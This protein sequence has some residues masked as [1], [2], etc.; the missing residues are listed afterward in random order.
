MTEKRLILGKKGEDFAADFLIKKGYK[1]KERNYRSPLG[2]IDI[3]ATSGKTIVFIEVKTRSS[4]QFGLPFEAVTKRKQGQIEKTALYY[5]AKKKIREHAARVDVV[6]IISNG[7]TLKAE[8]I[9]NAFDVA[10]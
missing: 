8:L 2:E 9:E 10:F 4:A 7:D 5:M 6:S 1:I 3:I